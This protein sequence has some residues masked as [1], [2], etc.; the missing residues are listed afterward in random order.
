MWRLDLR[1]SFDEKNKAAYSKVFELDQVLQN[2]F[3]HKLGRGHYRL[4]VFGGYLKEHLLGHW[5]NLKNLINEPVIVE[6]V[7]EVHE[8]EDDL[9]DR[10]HFLF[11]DIWSPL[12]EEDIQQSEWVL[13]C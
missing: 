12:F 9:K 11:K 6:I 4:R 1:E 2:F 13:L 5:K 7:S 8:L 3:D 10:H